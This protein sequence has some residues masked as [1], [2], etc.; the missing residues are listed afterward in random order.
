M[1][2]LAVGLSI[3]FA[4]AVLFSVEEKPQASK[5]PVLRIL[6]PGECQGSVYVSAG[7]ARIP[8]CTRT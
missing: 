5:V 1:R 7:D 8:T 2:E 6:K 4:L 3:I